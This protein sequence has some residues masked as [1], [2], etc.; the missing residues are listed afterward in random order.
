MSIMVVHAYEYVHRQHRDTYETRGN[1]VQLEVKANEPGMLAHCRTLVSE[2]A[3]VCTYMWLEVCKNPD[4]LIAHIDSP[5]VAKHAKFLSD[6]ILAHPSRIEIFGS[7][8]NEDKA[9]LSAKIDD[10][11][12]LPS[13]AAFYRTA[14]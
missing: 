3:D 14:E 9:R 4:A 13:D 1:A 7:L 2:D 6:G 8:T 12:F 10:I 11:V 5:H